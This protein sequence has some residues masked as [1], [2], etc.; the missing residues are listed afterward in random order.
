M[1]LPLII[2]AILFVQSIY[3]SNTFRASSGISSPKRYFFEQDGAYLEILSDTKK[4]SGQTEIDTPKNSTLTT[5]LDLLAKA[6]DNDS[7]NNRKDS[8]TVVIRT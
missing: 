2:L 4:D 5:W 8:K 6:V 1:R 3:S 7:L